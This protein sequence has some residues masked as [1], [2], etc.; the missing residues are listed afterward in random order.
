MFRVVA[1]ME[2]RI[3]PFVRHHPN[4]PAPAAVTARWTAA[5]HKFFAT[6]GRHAVTAVAALNMN[7]CA[8]DEHCQMSDTRG[9]RLEVRG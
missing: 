2:Q 5:G 9:Q 1:Q 4:I 8:I 3:E 7:L 6:K